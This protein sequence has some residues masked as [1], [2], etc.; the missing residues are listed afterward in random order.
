MDEMIAIFFLDIFDHHFLI[1]S[2][3][4]MLEVRTTRSKNRTEK[5]LDWKP[6]STADGIV[7]KMSTQLIEGLPFEE[8]LFSGHQTPIQAYCQS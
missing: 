2:G 6:V 4:K 3:Y 8:N 5:L 7:K 1:E